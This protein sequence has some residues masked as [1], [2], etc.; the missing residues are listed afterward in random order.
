MNIN[1]NKNIKI[2]VKKLFSIALV[3]IGMTVIPACQT[4][5][6]VYNYARENHS[7]KLTITEDSKQVRRGR[8]SGT[9]I[10]PAYFGGVISTDSSGDQVLIVDEFGYFTNWFD[11]WTQALHE[12]GGSVKIELNKDRS[13]NIVVREEL[14]VGEIKTAQTRYADLYY[15]GDR[16]NELL[17]N[18]IA[19]IKSVN[20]YLVEYGMP[21]FF[22]S[23]IYPPV[24]STSKSDKK[25]KTFFEATR[26]LL[27]PEMYP[28]GAV[29][30]DYQAKSTYELADS[31]LWNRQYSEKMFPE[32]LRDVRNGGSLYKDYEESIELFY[33][34][35]N[36]DYFLR[37]LVLNTPLNTPLN[38]Q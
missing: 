20:E 24:F 1:R 23:A 9:L 26:S 38:S 22:S 35:Y 18:R 7:V 17:R 4:V 15:K 28:F 30:V 32:H 14:F 31:I 2:I 36:L 13:F 3:V 21:M 11:G 16:A 6:G 5:K 10:S 29:K 27:F 19:R 34:F 33:V 12:A 8:L 25:Q 37:M